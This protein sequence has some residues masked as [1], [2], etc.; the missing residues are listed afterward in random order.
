MH[1]TTLEVV[2]ITYKKLTLYKRS[3]HRFVAGIY[4]RMPSSSVGSFCLFTKKLELFTVFLNL[5]I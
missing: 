5:Y 1:K 4:L 3:W 2:I